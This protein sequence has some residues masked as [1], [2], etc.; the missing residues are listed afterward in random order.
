MA[1]PHE[2]LNAIPEPIKVI[3]DVTSASVALVALVNAL[4]SIAAGLSIIWLGWQMW[5]RWKYGPKS[6]RIDGDDKEGRE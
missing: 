3:A 6:L 1:T 2:V 5:D 4:P